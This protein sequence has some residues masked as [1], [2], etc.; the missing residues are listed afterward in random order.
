MR[1]VAHRSWRRLSSAARP[2]SVDSVASSWNNLSKNAREYGPLLTLLVGGLTTFTLGAYKLAIIHTQIETE[3]R[4]SEEKIKAMRV[5]VRE[6]IK[7]VRAEAI[8]DTANKY[9]LYGFDKEYI[10]YHKQAL[11]SANDSSPDKDD[12]K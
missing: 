10:E 1:P 11:L 12:E 6:R 4:V 5:A 3:R 7:A 2:S 8:E 9:I